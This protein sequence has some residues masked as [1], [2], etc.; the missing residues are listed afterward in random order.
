MSA[1]L[2]ANAALRESLRR[3]VAGRVPNGEVEDLLQEI[4]LRLLRASA[5]EHLSGYAYRVARTV[6]ADFYRQRSVEAPPPEEPEDENDAAQ[7]VASWLR[8][9]IEALDEPWASALVQTEIEGR[10]H[11]EVAA[12]LGVPRSTVSSRVARGRE[13]LRKSIVRCCEIELDVRGH[14][15]GWEKRS[16]CCD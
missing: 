13:L 15:I 7:V 2:E 12:A 5:V 10:S 16:A 9:M 14:V 6:I 11:A 8:P 4:Y 1:A 3:F